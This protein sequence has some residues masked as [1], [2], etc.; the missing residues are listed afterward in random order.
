ME[1]SQIPLDSDKAQ[2][3]KH[4]TGQDEVEAIKKED[5]T[6]TSQNPPVSDEAPEQKHYTRQ[7]AVEPTKKE[8]STKNSRSLP[9]SVK[10]VIVQGKSEV[11]AT[12][13]E[14][15]SVSEDLV[16]AKQEIAKLQVE[17][18]SFG[19]KK[20][21]NFDSIQAAEKT[22]FLVLQKVL[23]LLKDRLEEK[24]VAA[25]ATSMEI[26]SEEPLA[27]SGKDS[28]HKSK[29]SAATNPKEDLEGL[30]RDLAALQSSISERKQTSV[31]LDEW[32][33]TRGGTGHQD[34]SS[35]KIDLKLSEA[36]ADLQKAMVAEAIAV[37]NAGSKVDELEEVKFTLKK[38]ADEN[39]T[40]SA[41]V[42]SLRI[43]WNISKA[44]LDSI[45]D[46]EK[47]AVAVVAAIKDEIK[48]VKADAAA[49]LA[50][51]SMSKKVISALTTGLQEMSIEADKAK[52]SHKEAFEEA[53]SAKIV[54]RHAKAAS[55]TRE[56]QLKAA[57]KEAEAAK[58]S[59]AFALEEI[60]HLSQPRIQHA[61]QNESD[62]EIIG[63][64]Q[65]DSLRKQLEETQEQTTKTLAE[66]MNSLKAEQGAEQELLKQLQEAMADIE[67][68]KLTK[69]Q[70]LQQAEAAE[71]GKVAV[72]GELRKWRA[73]NRQ[74]RAAADTASSV[75]TPSPTYSGRLLTPEAPE[76][77]HR[78]PKTD[79]FAQVYQLSL[80]PPAEKIY[81]VNKKQITIKKMNML[82]RVMSFFSPKR[83]RA[84]A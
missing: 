70:A 76:R 34:V 32:T 48:K 10:R 2:E 57:Y 75:A 23:D 45:I 36:V 53:R 78:H 22:A 1:I 25:N 4:C 18:R 33:D 67:A 56:Y 51:E 43:R 72:E 81:P 62:V 41:T 61:S 12:E 16:L 21:D 80:P 26:S 65:Y 19:E 73:E 54:A 83:R 79:H 40:L 37:Q 71:A 14:L 5:C 55:V 52:A 7:D 69:Q 60:K 13:K 82:A 20:I 49:A 77:N 68:S 31:T 9:D 63:K 27:V 6:E 84:M 8:D 30:I 58:A 66:A 42:E 3:Q 38:A 15:T 17:I 47:T 35:V 28:E 59:E 24:L 44:E 11:E 29:D 64:E 46:R 50:A 74:R 39:A